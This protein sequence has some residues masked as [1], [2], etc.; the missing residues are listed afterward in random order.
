VRKRL[1]GFDMTSDTPDSDAG[2]LSD[3]LGL[4]PRRMRLWRPED[5]GAVFAH[6]M[7]APIVFD[8]GAADAPTAHALRLLADAQGL[9]IKSFGDL[10]RHPSPPLEL[11]RLTKDFAKANRDHPEAVLP[12]EIAHALYYASIAVALVR[13]DTR[14][15]RLTDAELR[16]GFAC[17]ADQP[18]VDGPMKDMFAQAMD[19]LSGGARGK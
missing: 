5:L 13:C 6:Q 11:L 4:E 9:L 17:V 14:I 1:W 2:R 3:L 19:K 18:W 16:R 12:V 7:A 15:S 10:F 8:L